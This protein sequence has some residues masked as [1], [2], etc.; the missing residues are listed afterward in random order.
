[1]KYDK[2]A[3]KSRCHEGTMFNFCLVVIKK[4]NMSIYIY[5]QYVHDFTYIHSQVHKLNQ[6]LGI[7]NNILSQQVLTHSSPVLYGDNMGI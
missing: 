4:H 3:L 1:M 6:G 7:F 5:V 2:T